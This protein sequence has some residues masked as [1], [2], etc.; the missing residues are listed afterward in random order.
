MIMPA[1]IKD[2]AAVE[3]FS[4]VAFVDSNDIQRPANWLTLAT[5]KE[6]RSKPTVSARATCPASG[7]SMSR[8]PPQL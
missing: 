8:A 3:L 7:R 2:G 6:K 4:G 1:I 5:V